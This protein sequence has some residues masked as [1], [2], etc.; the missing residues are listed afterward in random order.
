MAQI[1]MYLVFMIIL[2]YCF[3]IVKVSGRSMLPTFNP[4]SILI[5]TRFKYKLQV[6]KVYVFT[7]IDEDGGEHI[8]V[9]RLIEVTELYGETVCFFL[10]DNE[11]ESYDSRH[12]G[13]INAENIIARVLWKVKD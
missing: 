9:K 8:V 1:I 7:R 5:A 6:G 11:A 12:Y 4:N 10:G 13:Y 3:P 2:A